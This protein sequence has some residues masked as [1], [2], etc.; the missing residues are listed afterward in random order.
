MFCLINTLLFHRETMLR[1][2]RTAKPFLLA[3]RDSI[4]EFDFKLSLNHNVDNYSDGRLVAMIDI[5]SHILPGIDDGAAD[6][7]H[8]IALARAAEEEGI[9]DLVATP[10]HY[11]GKYN[12]PIEIVHHLTEQLNERLR[13]QSIPL[14]VHQGQEI[15]IHHELL[16]NWQEGKLLGLAG[17]K[18]VLLEMPASHVP[19][20][21]EQMVYELKLQDV[22]VVIAHPERNAEIVKSPDCLEDL[23]AAGAYA[24]VTSHSLL[25]G[26]GRGIERAAWTLSRRGLI[27]F[28]ASD[29]HNLSWRGFRLKEAYERVTAEMG[30]EWSSYYE[31]NA[32]A[33]LMNTELSSLPNEGQLK[34][35]GGWGR[36]KSLFGN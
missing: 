33:L 19:H 1:L 15:H 10:H 11:D 18:Y 9:T 3:A 24:Q 7:E 36:I 30:E 31:Q 13:E 16:R 14:K 35:I 27:H 8:S 26:F 4:A 2:Q 6:W 28:V 22:H 25:G 29:A 21:M 17:S 20:A 34:R 23:I 5:H 32:H 12:N